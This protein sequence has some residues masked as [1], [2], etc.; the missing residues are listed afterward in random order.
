MFSD[1]VKQAYRL[2]T[3]KFWCVVLGALLPSLAL[4]TVDADGAEADRYALPL[5]DLDGRKSMQTVVDR[6]KGQYLGHP[7]T[8]LLDDGRTIYCV[9]PK[10]HGKGAIVMKRSDDGGKTW[11][12]RLKTP[13]NWQTSREVPTLY[14]MRGPEEGS[15]RLVMFSGLYPIRMAISDDMGESWSRLKPIGE[16]G[17]IVTMAD[18]ARTGEGRYMA[19]FHDDGRFIDGGDQRHRGSPAGE[20]TGEMT[21]YKTITRDGGRTWSEPEAIFSRRAQH[22]CEPGLV[23]SPD[24]ETLAMLLRENRRRDNSHIAFSHDDGDTWS[25][26]RE[27]PAVL[28]GDRHQ[29]AY[30]PDGRLFISFRDRTPEGYDSPTEGDWVGWVG[31]WAD[32]AN[33]RKG[34]TDVGQY[35]VRLKDNH[36]AW[37][38]AYPAIEVLPDGTFVA[39][40]YGHWTK[41]R[42]PY[43]LSL[44]FRLKQLDGMVEP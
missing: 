20:P 2:G 3:A 33:A 19:L 18:V 29:A 37:D 24:G 25:E 17:G 44:R 21:V 6:E 5:V 9:Y 28:T 40:T 11:S 26:P 13:Q 43:I 27:L 30:G 12:P 23:R 32:L 35:R 7:S 1:L 22:L 10:G 16:F 39:T 8:V 15:Q 42:A 38:C 36:H 34:D 41:G 31:T 14:K 4:T